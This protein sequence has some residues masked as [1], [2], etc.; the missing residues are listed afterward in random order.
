MADKSWERRTL[1]SYGSN[2]R[3]D[4]NN[5]QTTVGG[6]DIYNIYGITDEE[7][8]CLMGLQQNGIFRIYNNKTVEIVGGQKAGENGI[9]IVIAGKN[10]DVLINADKNGRVRIRGKNVVIQADEDVDISA[11]RNVNIKSGSGRVLLGGN[12]LEKSGLKGN[13]LDPEQQWAFRVFENTGLPAGAFGD[14]LSGFSGITN[15]ATQL[16]ANPAAFGQV[17]S[18]SVIGGVTDAIGGAIPGGLGAAGDIIG[19]G[20][21]NLGSNL[22]SGLGDFA[23]GL[24]SDLTSNVAGDIASSLGGGLGDFAGGLVGDAAGDAL[25]NLTDNLGSDLGS[26]ISD[27][28]KD[29]PT[30]SEDD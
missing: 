21:G 7:D 23:G 15:I 22:T 8:V 25:G 6:S 12:T 11:G 17:L 2:F 16:A 20:L 14:L 29:N 1:L 4:V 13:L 26:T 27:I 10:G 9:D 18:S 30:E 28:I 3:I 5:P 24:A 19:G